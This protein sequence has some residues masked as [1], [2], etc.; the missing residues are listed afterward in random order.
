[1]A[2]PEKVVGVLVLQYRGCIGRQKATPSSQKFVFG[3][4]D[5][6]H[7]PGDTGATVGRAWGAAAGR[8]E[9]GAVGTTVGAFV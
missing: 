5:G 6:A 9:V 1:M 2:H 8:M 4:A 3:F 7:I